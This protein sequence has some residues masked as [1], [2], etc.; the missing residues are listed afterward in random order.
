MLS[1]SP[2]HRISKSV[3]L[4]IAS[5]CRLMPVPLRILIYRSLSSLGARFYGPSCSLNAQQLPFSMYLKTKSVEDHRALANKF[6]ALQLERSQTEIPVPR[7]LG[8]VSDTD[9][10]YLLTTALPGQRFGSYIDIL[11]DHDLDLFVRDMQKFLEQLRSITR[12]RAPKYEIGNAIDGP[13]YD[14]RIIA[15]RGYDKE[16]GD[17]FGPFISEEDF[18]DTL[19]TPALTD[20]FHSQGHE[21]V[22]THSDN[23]R[24][25]LVHNGR[26]SGIVDRE[27]SG[28]FPDYWEYTKAHYVTKLN[29]RWLRVVDRIFERCGNFRHDLAIEYRLWEY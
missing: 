19:R 16:R 10:S 9:T 13:C 23:M 3:A 7:P 24:N 11:S 17:F 18:N 4:A 27:N 5:V 26:I 21:I 20:V 8:L 12:Q 29:K 25:I 22:F 1:F 15:A 6:G 28:W 14:Y 2:W